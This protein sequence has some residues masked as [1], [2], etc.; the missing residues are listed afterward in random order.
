MPPLSPLGSHMLA[1]ITIPSS[2]AA[3]RPV[4]R[5]RVAVGWPCAAV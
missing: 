3:L 2:A 5:L 4:A 1:A